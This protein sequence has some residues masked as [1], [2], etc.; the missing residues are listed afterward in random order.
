MHAA[1]WKLLWFDLCGSFRGLLQ[2]RRSWRKLLLLLLMLAF[3]GLFILSQAIGNSGGEITA[4]GAGGRFGDAMPFWAALYLIATWLTSSADRGLVMRPAEIHFI[5]AGPFPSR[6]IITLNLIRL[7]YRAAISSVVLAL[8][9]M[10]F[11]RSFPSALMGL[12]LLIAVSLLVGMVVSLSARR[13]H[14]VAIHRLRRMGTVVALAMLIT[15]IMQSMELIRSHD[16]M[17]TVPKIAAAALETPV[18]QYVLPPLKWMFAPLSNDAFWPSTVLMLPGRFLVIAVLVG[19]IY[20][21]GGD[22]LEASTT[23]TDLSV[24]RRQSSLRSGVSGRSGWTRRLTLPQFGRW[25]GIGP[26]ARMQMLHSLRILPR[27]MVFTV[28]IVSVVIVI[29][30]TVDRQQL[31]GWSGVLWM[32]GLNAYADFLL[33]LQ[34][35][36]GFL[37]PPA[38][39]AMLKSL[40]IPN[41]AIV[42]GQLAGPFIPLALIHMLVLALFLFL[43][44]GSAS[45]VIQTA[46]ALIPVAWVLTANINLLGAWNIIKPRALQQRDALAAGR[47]MLSVWIFF[48]MLIPAMVGGIIG[49]AVAIKLRGATLTSYL[50]GASLGVMLTSLLYVWLLTY[51]F[52][53]SQPSAADLGAEEKEHDA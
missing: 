37:G 29:P 12:W 11:M 25:F 34:L 2:V 52:G 21:L 3:M 38:Q 45:E 5:V 31:Q 49:A 33:L 39:R 26:I 16:G 51:T 8:L 1:L 18:G 19:L 13:A 48:M 9:G 6:D 15:M 17:V 43:L 10:A 4:S 23:R 24:E 42:L 20:L 7:A 44:P 47:A 32:F 28:A 53:R 27:F 22:Y 35:P 14:G 30:M 36:V 40:P 46:L 41:W 50:G